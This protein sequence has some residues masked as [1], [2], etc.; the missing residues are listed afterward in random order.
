MQAIVEK[1]ETVTISMTMEEAKFLLSMVQNPLIPNEPKNIEEFRKNIW[2]SLISKGVRLSFYLKK[3]NE[4]ITSDT[5]KL[6]GRK[7][8]IGKC[9]RLTPYCQCTSTFDISVCLFRK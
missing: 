5:N 1:I 3:D 8:C 4:K 2:D 9:F 6:F 7:A